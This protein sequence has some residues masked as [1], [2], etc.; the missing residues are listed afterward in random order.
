[1]YEAVV[2]TAFGGTIL[3]L[4]AIYNWLTPHIKRLVN[5]LRRRSQFYE[6][7]YGE[8][9]RPGVPGREGVMVRLL[10]HEESLAILMERTQELCTNSGESIKDKVNYLDTQ[11]SELSVKVDRITEILLQK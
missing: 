1:M 6:D 7:W 10:N 3:L 8:A 5:N 9:G 11:V 4:I 2:L